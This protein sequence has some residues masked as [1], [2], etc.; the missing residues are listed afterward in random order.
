[1]QQDFRVCLSLSRHDCGAN[2]AQADAVSPPGASQNKTVLLAVQDEGGTVEV[3]GRE[4]PANFEFLADDQSATL[5]LD[6][7]TE[8]SS[9][10]TPRQGL[11][12]ADPAEIHTALTAPVVDGPL[13]APPI[14]G[15]ASKPPPRSNYTILY[16]GVF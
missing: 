2:L 11:Q 9:R 12:I 14:P 16:A 6:L 1:M 10:W 5:A 15:V 13:T 7:Q 4:G 3:R 8:Y